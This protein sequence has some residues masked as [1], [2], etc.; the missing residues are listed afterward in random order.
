[1]L[2]GNFR[3]L[4]K[5]QTVL[6]IMNNVAFFGTYS[7]RCSCF[8]TI[9]RRSPTTTILL[10]NQI[11][12]SQNWQYF[13]Y[14]RRRSIDHEAIYHFSRYCRHDFFNVWLWKNRGAWY[15]QPRRE[16][17]LRFIIVTVWYQ[18]PLSTREK[19]ILILSFALTMFTLIS[20]LAGMCNF[21]RGGSFR[22]GLAVGGITALI[23][24]GLLIAG[25]KSLASLGHW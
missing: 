24:F 11:A 22:K 6:P 3:R 10:W 16:E 12:S 5:N 17:D 19:A 15:Q 8:N 14:G 7:V 13:K 18:T 20:L 2:V 1:M 21:Y 25:L 23:I 9:R 4:V